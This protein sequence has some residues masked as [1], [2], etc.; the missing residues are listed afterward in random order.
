MPSP[1][2]GSGL[3]NRYSRRMSDE[4]STRF[5]SSRACQRAPNSWFKLA[6]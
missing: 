2:A 5:T 6:K 4:L 3:P 1:L